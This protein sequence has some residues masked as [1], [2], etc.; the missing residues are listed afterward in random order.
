MR[1]FTTDVCASQNHD[2]NFNASPSYRHRNMDHMLGIDADPEKW[3]NSK[4]C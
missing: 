3:N 2:E 4:E 1:D